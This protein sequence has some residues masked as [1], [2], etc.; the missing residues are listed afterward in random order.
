MS[1]LKESIMTNSPYARKKAPI[2]LATWSVLS[3][4]L[5]ARDKVIKIIQYAARLLMWYYQRI[6]AGERSLL[7][8]QKVRKEHIP[9]YYK[10]YCFVAAFLFTGNAVDFCWL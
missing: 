9:T 6:N 8:I 5:S 3:L 7:A 10:L 1:L 4:N 2:N